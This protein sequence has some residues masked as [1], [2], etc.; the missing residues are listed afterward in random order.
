[1]SAKCN[2]EDL[3]QT[4]KAARAEFDHHLVSHS[5]EAGNAAAMPVISEIPAS[6]VF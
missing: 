6:R 2:P 1:M 5:A 4:Y 3:L